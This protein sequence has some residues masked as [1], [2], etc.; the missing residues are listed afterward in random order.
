MIPAMVIQQSLFEST[1]NE[2]EHDKRKGHDRSITSS[3]AKEVQ[4]TYIRR[5]RPYWLA[6]TRGY[7]TEEIDF[8]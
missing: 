4:R 6:L 7:K 8:Q 5:I 1:I 3:L 2:R